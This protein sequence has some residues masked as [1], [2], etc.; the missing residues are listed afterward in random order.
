LTLLTAF[1]EASAWAAEKPSTLVVVVKGSSDKLRTM[2]DDAMPKS[3]T[4][5]NANAVA[6]AS[7]NRK[8]PAAPPID[9]PSAKGP[10]LQTL[11]QVATDVGAKGAVA[12]QVYKVGKKRHAHVI[13]ISAAG[14]TIADTDVTLGAPGEDGSGV[15]EGFL[16]QLPTLTG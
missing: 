2:I 13:L 4:V 3:W 1:G 15:A 7:K 9:D 5:A 11:A 16:E 8:L 12:V 14:A 10:Y 6:T